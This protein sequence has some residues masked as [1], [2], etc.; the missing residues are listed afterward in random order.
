MVEATKVA[1]ERARSA[2]EADE[3]LEDKKIDAENASR[4]L[5]KLTSDIMMMG[6]A[7]SSVAE[8]PSIFSDDELTGWQKAGMIIGNLT[9]AIFSFGSGLLNMATDAPKFIAA[10]A[11][12][13][14]ATL[15][16]IAV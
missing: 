4:S 5:T 8:L 14:V 6:V 16:E 1:N 12:I 10:M 9:T 2:L 7:W 15:K 11:G 13:D 3:S